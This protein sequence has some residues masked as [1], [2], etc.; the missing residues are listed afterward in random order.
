MPVEADFDQAGSEDNMGE[1]IDQVFFDGFVIGG[2]EISEET[3]DFVLQTFS[4]AGK[5]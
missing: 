4:F 3:D 2:S 5:V 1:R